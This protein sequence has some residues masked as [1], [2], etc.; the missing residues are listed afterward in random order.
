M[1]ESES[2]NHSMAKGSERRLHYNQTQAGLKFEIASPHIYTPVI[3]EAAEKS[4]YKK[5]H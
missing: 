4:T 1:V 2:R 3:A 5:L